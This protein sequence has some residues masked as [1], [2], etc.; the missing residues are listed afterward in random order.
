MTDARERQVSA[1]LDEEQ[2][3]E[4]L[5][6]ADPELAGIAETIERVRSARTFEPASAGFEERGW[7]R[8]LQETKA[9]PTVV[10]EAPPARR[11]R[12]SWRKRG[13]LTAAASLMVA[14]AVFSSQWWSGETV[15]ASEIR[16]TGSGELADLGVQAA[17]YPRYAGNLDT[18]TYGTDDRV[19][20]WNRVDYTSQAF[21]LG[22]AYM[23]DM[24][25][26]PDGSLAAFV[27]YESGT[28]G[29]SSP[30]LWVVQ[31]DGSAPKEIAKPGD[32]DTAYESP[33]WSPD[34]KKIAFTATHATLSDE[35]GVVQEQ[36]VMIVNADGTGLTAVA[37]GKEPSWSRDGSQIA[38]A[39]PTDSG[40]TEIHIVDVN[41]SGHDRAL[42]SGSQPA[43]SPNG[44]FIAFVKTRIEHRALRTDAKGKE[45]FTADVTYQE[46]WAVNAESGKETPLTTGIYPEDRIKR[47]LAESDAK[48]ETSAAYTVSAISSEE[49]P[50]WSPDGARIVF[51]R[52]TNEE[53]G[54]HFALQELNIAYR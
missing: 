3:W 29:P 16:V 26:S 34:G 25:W 1:L 35:T 54:P 4:R 17:L 31:R 11:V 21:P 47:L 12:P 42:V 18:V 48:G 43:W 36:R 41:G 37:K 24:A 2:D 15:S 6:S 44:P 33:V 8:I 23:R 10:K 30:G 53:K 9:T 45:T 40:I 19:N 50:A 38:Y 52:N 49:S 20:V 14:A 5:L 27:G 13:W 28:P 32:D 46:L 39:A 22:F 7:Q 51:S